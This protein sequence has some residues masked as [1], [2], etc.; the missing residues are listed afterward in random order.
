MRSAFTT[1][2]ERVILWPGWMEVESAVKLRIFGGG[3]IGKPS[4]PARP[5]AGAWLPLGAGVCCPATGKIINAARVMAIQILFLSCISAYPLRRKLRVRILGTMI[6]AGAR[7]R[8]S[9]PPHENK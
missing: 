2:Q 1:A 5:G 4:A 8:T 3:P 9:T 7:K 6:G